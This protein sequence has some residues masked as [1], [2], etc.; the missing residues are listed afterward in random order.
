MLLT[1]EGRPD[2]LGADF[3]DIDHAAAA[4]ATA[5][6][7]TYLVLEGWGESYIQAA[8]SGGRFMIEY[9]DVYGEGFRHWRAFQP[10][11]TSTAPTVVTF[12]QRCPNRKHPRRGCPLSVL[13]CDV[14]TVEDVAEALTQYATDGTRTARLQWRDVSDEFLPGDDDFRVR[15]IRPQERPDQPEA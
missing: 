12:R 4:L 5:D 6:G 14:T 7:P 15:D 8:G 11:N 2:V 3:E 1:V 13:A 9:R 10:G